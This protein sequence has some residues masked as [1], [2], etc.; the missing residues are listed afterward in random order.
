MPTKTNESKCILITGAGAGIGATTAQLFVKNGWRVGLYDRDLHAVQALAASLGDNAHAGLLDVTQA[1][2]WDQALADFMAWSGRL[3]VLLN[4]AGILYSGPF[5]SINLQDHT[6]LLQV[7]VQGVINGCHA[8]LPYLQQSK[9]AR[10]I[11]LSSASALYGQ[12]NLATYSASK[13]AIRG[14]TEALDGEWNR[15]GIRVMDIMPL[16]VQTAMVKD[17]N[18]GSIKRLGVNLTPSDVASVILK[19]ANTHPLLAPTHWPVGWP[20]RALYHMVGMTPDRLNKLI[21]GWL[22]H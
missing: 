13:F 21:N 10:V 5:E 4:N 1:N 16:F 15:Y 17:M 19:A 2:Q 20:A 8:A 6:R 3:D 11:N 12:Q 14:L 18:A 22:G 7:N 9:H